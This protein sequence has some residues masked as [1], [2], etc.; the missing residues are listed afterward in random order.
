MSSPQLGSVNFVGH[1]NKTARVKDTI[2]DGIFD[3]PMAS[4]MTSAFAYIHIV[5]LPLLRLL[6]SLKP[7]EIAKMRFLAIWID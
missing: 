6:F 5:H 1:E 7:K 4:T 3:L 2:V